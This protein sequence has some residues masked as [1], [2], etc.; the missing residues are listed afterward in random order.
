MATQTQNSSGYKAFQAT[1]VAIGVGKR[2]FI[3]TSVP[4]LI[5]VA[6]ATVGAIGVTMENI[7]ASGYGTVK[8]FNAP[9]TFIMCAN[10]AIVAGAQ[11][12]PTA[13]GNVDDAGTT[14][15]PLVALE[16]ATAQ[17]DLIECGPFFLGA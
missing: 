17:N 8:L 16:A 7:A 6:G 13:A 12:Y 5:A 11:L 15:L 14:A 2:V 3:D 4:P 1:A 9:G 10:A